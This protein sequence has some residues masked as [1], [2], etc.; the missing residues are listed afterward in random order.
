MR[1]SILFI[2]ITTT[3][4]VFATEM[5][6]DIW[7]RRYVSITP[8]GICDHPG[9]Q[10]IIVTP[11]Q[12]QECIEIIKENIIDCVHVDYKDNFPAKITSVEE[13][14]E[15]DVKLIGCSAD[16]DNFRGFTKR[17]IELSE[18]PGVSQ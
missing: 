10:K 8:I 5:D 9:F 18:Q 11:A 3:F 14:T 15:W 4:P 2:L 16:R 17:L 13:A 1:L 12:R 7:L 6:S